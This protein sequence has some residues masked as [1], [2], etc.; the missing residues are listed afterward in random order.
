MGEGCFSDGGT[1]FLS[2]GHPIGGTLVL[3]GLA[4]EGGFKKNQ[5]MGVAPHAPPTMGNPA[6]NRWKIT[7]SMSYFPTCNLHKIIK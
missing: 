6:L 2:G 4:G 5:K 1:L 7:S 3:V